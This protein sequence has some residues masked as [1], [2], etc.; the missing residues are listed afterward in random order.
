[1]VSDSRAEDGALQEAS[2]M[3]DVLCPPPG[4]AARQCFS[5]GNTEASADGPMNT[6]LSEVLTNLHAPPCWWDLV[7]SHHWRPGKRALHS[8]SKRWTWW[9]MGFRQPSCLLHLKAKM[10]FS[11]GRQRHFQ[12]TWPLCFHSHLVKETKIRGEC[13]R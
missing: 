11:P 7:V 4:A 13:N 3:P 5:V 2:E 9:R 1:M 6:P 10:Y 12:W 8:F